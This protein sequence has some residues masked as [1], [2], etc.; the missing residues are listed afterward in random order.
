MKTVL[1]TGASGIIGYGILRSLRKSCLDLKLI[2]TT[3]YTDSVAPAFCDI[4]ELAPPSDDQ[5]YID[6]LLRIISKHNVDLIV[7]G[8][9]TDIYKW[10]DHIPE[11]E[12]SGARIML[13]NP[14]LIKLCRDKWIFYR[15][16]CKIGI[17]YAINTSLNSDYNILKKKFGLPFLLKPRRGDGSKGIVRIETAKVF[18]RYK[19]DIGSLTMAQPIVG[20][21][22]EEFTTS[23]FCDGQGGFYASMTLKRKLSK[24]GF[25]EKAE[26][27]QESG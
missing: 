18:A 3:I 15:S 26:V 7:P 13:N 27:S 24:E 23:A 19:K 9:E 21:E 8:I 6:W 10:V 2:G 12:K 14:E 22:N 1:V 4:F 17:P 5:G 20:N 11:L 25:T 16:L